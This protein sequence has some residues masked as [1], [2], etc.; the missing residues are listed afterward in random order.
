MQE[1]GTGDNTAEEACCRS[2]GLEG[3][4]GSVGSAW[5]FPVGGVEGNRSGK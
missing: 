2:G 5:V 1:H 4:M 3:A